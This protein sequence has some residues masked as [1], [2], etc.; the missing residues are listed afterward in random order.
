[1]NTKRF[2]NLFALLMALVLCVTALT[3][4]NTKTPTVDP[5]ETK[6]NE[7]LD[8]L[9]KGNYTGAYALFTELGDYKDA[10]KMAARFHYAP[11]SMTDKYI[12]AEGQT[13]E[14][15]TFT[16]NEKNLPMTCVYASD[17]GYQ[18][19]CTY[20]YNEN[21]QITKIFCTDTDGLEECTEYEYDENGYMIKEIAP[22]NGMIYTIV[23]TYTEKGNVA[24]LAA[25]VSD[26]T[27]YSYAYTYDENGNEILCVI[28]EGDVTLTYETVYDAEGKKIAEYQKD[29][30]GNETFKT[31]YTYDEKGR[32]TKETFSIMG[33]EKGFYEYAYDDKNQVIRKHYNVGDGMYVT[34]EYTYDAH[35]NIIKAHKNGY[36]NNEVIHD[37][38]FKLVYVPCDL[39]AEGWQTILDHIIGW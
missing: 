1:M 35:G 39:N 29:A 10:A 22:Y 7:A 26:G 9:E 2:T 32:T 11:V 23:Y 6:Y 3:A 21:G 12:D 8:L 4:C 15:A 31:S 25:T 27:S 34:F 20:T 33:E 13:I 28:T 36:D 38:E 19:T 17:D 5:K 16:Y 37:A 30:D 14:N 18:H 24:T